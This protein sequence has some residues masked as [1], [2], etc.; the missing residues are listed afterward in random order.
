MIDALPVK[1]LK[2]YVLKKV[3]M[4]FIVLSVPGIIILEHRWLMLAGM[5]FGGAFGIIKF[6]ATSRSFSM[7]LASV[8]SNKAPGLTVLKYL[9]YLFATIALLAAALLLDTCFFAGTAAGV[10]L[11]PVA[12]MID[13]IIKAFGVLRSGFAKRG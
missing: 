10:L 8:S 6:G 5:V 13:G 2:A 1:E 11:V 4:L 12:I 7:M 3:L 9:V